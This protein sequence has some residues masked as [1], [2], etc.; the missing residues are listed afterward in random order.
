MVPCQVK[1]GQSVVWPS[2]PAMWLKSATWCLLRHSSALLAVLIVLGGSL[3]QA[4]DSRELTA[5]VIKDDLK[6]EVDVAGVFVADDKDEIAME[7]SK[8]RGDLIVTHILP[9]GTEVKEGDVLMEFDTDKLDEALEEAGN[10]A[11]DAEVD[12][13]DLRLHSHVDDDGRFVFEN[14][15]EGDYLIRVESRSSDDPKR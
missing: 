7:P 13:V 11:T 6:I 8:Y 4:Q 9:E 12:L 2:T 1:A 14:V 3:A 15:P 10:E 5:K